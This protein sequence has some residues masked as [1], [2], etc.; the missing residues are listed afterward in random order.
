MKKNKI[1]FTKTLLKI[2]FLSAIALFMS[3]CGCITGQGPLVQ[4]EKSISAVKH[5][6][7]DIEGDIELIQSAESKVV[8]STNS[9]VQKHIK[10]VE[11]GD[12][13]TIKSGRCFE[14]S[15]NISIKLS[16]PQ[17]ESITINTNAQLKSTTGRI[18][19]ENFSVESNGS[20]V[21]NLL[22]STVNLKIKTTARSK[23]FVNGFTGDLNLSLA[24]RAQFFGLG[25]ASS[26]STVLLQGTSKAQLQVHKKLEAV[27]EKGA[28]LDYRG[29]QGLTA[30]ISGEGKVK[31]LE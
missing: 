25:L 3:A 20:G 12:R 19:V 10:L 16:L 27:I 28:T 23:V 2:L 6:I 24:D 1:V 21:I 29:R 14:Q 8:V 7:I 18:N 11:R 13:L 31:E 9:N 22:V 5:V 15:P 17:P 26:T 4:K 30:N